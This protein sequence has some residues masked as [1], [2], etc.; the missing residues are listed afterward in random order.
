[1]TSLDKH[2]VFCFYESIKRDERGFVEYV[3]AR[4]IF[5]LLPVK[6]SIIE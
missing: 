2:T 6:P 4:K 1:M 5:P 3:A